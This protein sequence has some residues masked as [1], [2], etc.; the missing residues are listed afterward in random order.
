MEKKKLRVLSVSPRSGAEGNEEKAASDGVSATG[1]GSEEKLAGS[2]DFGTSMCSL[3]GTS[4]LLVG[5]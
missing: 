1:T 4:Q 3:F 5:P 2:D